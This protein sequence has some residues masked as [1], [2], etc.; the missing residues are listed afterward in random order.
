MGQNVKLTRVAVFA[1][2]GG[3]A[4]LAGVLYGGLNGSL[5]GTDFEFLFSLILLL[6]LAIWGVR[7]VS[8]ALLAGISYR[9]AQPGD[10]DD[11]DRMVRQTARQPARGSRPG[12]ASSC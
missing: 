3:M 12:S 7:T 6:V 4:G 2:S 1:V 9:A 8:G 11:L 5:A 10:H